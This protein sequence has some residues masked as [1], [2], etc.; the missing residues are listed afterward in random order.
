MG[1]APTQHLFQ[2]VTRMPHLC[3]PWPCHPA[4][5][6]CGGDAAW[7]FPASTLAILPGL[8]PGC[9]P[10]CLHSA[11]HRCPPPL[12]TAAWSLSWLWAPSPICTTLTFRLLSCPHLSGVLD[13][14]R[15]HKQSYVLAYYTAMSASEQ[16][17]S[18]LSKPTQQTRS[19]KKIL[20]P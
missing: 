13:R 4:Q 7:S 16:H 10:S 1:R 3:F 12:L 18:A 20:A 11:N 14:V 9:G 5:C 8:L 2:Q 6:R 17:L 15:K 19:Q